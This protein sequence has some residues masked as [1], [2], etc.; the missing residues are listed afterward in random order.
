MYELVPNCDGSMYAV[1]LFAAGHDWCA[2]AADCSGCASSAP[3][4]DS[5]DAVEILIRGCC[6]PASALL[7]ACAGRGAPFN[8]SAPGATDVGWWY[9]LGIEL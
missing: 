8:E 5:H 6:R 4:F 9:G 1:E 3:C 2:Y 7:V